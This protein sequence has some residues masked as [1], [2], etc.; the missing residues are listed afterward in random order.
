MSDGPF[1]ELCADIAA[2]LEIEWA[3]AGLLDRTAD[4]ERVV[5]GAKQRLAPIDAV[6]QHAEAGPAVGD[7]RRRLHREAP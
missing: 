2:A 3:R 1:D 6:D 5:G 4:P 7:P